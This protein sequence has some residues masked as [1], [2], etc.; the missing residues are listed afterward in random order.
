MGLGLVG[1]GARGLELVQGVFSGYIRE[2]GIW[3]F[4]MGWIWSVRQFFMG[5]MF[6]IVVDICSCDS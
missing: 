3:K 6:C 4:D 5:L 1:K 2:W